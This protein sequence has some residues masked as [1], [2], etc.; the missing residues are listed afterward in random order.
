[1]VNKHQIIDH[2]KDSII[3][4]KLDPGQRIVELQLAKELDSSRGTVREALRHLEQKGFVEIIPNIG[5]VVKELSAKEVVQIYDLMGVLEGL[6]M[7]IATPVIPLE[8]IGRIEGLVAKVEEV[9]G[10]RFEMSRA[11]YQFHR[12]LTELGGNDLLS[13]FMENIR[14]QTYRMRLQTFYSQEQVQATLAEH[15]QILTA[16]KDRNAEQ[17]EQLIRRHYQDAKKRLIKLDY[18]TY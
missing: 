3:R 7:R 12:F 13:Q 10:D 6:S 4:G 14:L 15:R 8:T 5:T 16:I 18:G 2:I 11:N 1:M 17:V 9:A